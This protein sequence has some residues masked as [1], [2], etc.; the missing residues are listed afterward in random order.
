MKKNYEP[1][2]LFLL[3]TDDTP[4]CNTLPDVSAGGIFGI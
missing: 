3:R 4:I 2:T 1:P